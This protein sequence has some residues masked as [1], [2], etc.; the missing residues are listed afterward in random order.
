MESDAILLSSRPVPHSDLNP[1]SLNDFQQGAAEPRLVII[2]PAAGGGRARHAA[3]GIL[4]ALTI[5]LG[6]G[7]GVRMTA[8]QFDAWKFAADAVKCGMRR[9]IVV[10]GDGTLQEVVNGLLSAGTGARTCSVGLLSCGTGCGF[11]QSIG[12]P[13]NP[14]KQ[15]DVACFGEAKSFDAGFLEY[16]DPVGRKRTRWF[17]NECQIGLGA[18]VC[19][20]VRRGHKSLGGRMAF[21]LG[22]LQSVMTHS[23]EKMRIRFDERESVDGKFTG[24]VAGNGACT[25]GG[26]NLV[27]G[28]RPDDGLLRVLLM[29]DLSRAERL[30]SFPKIYSGRH[31]HAPGF[32]TM[33]TTYMR[34]DT[35]E[36]SLVAA[37]GELLG[38]TPASVRV[39]PRAFSVVCPI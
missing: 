32:R 24:I 27:P 30:R 6:A 23:N 34:I 9:I 13:R 29:G 2:N 11:A 14:L 5:R 37:D 36:P 31:V 28:A 22:A 8:R 7:F 18:E 17:V 12:L 16:A 4:Q 1:T 38:T 25:G 15:I 33:D 39:S 10:G 35:E 26:M 3:D 20:T 19:R 21:G